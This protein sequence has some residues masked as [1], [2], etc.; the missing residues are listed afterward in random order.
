MYIIFTEEK[1]R[2]YV[3]PETLSG[4][5]YMFKSRKAAISAMDRVGRKYRVKLTLRREK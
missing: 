4:R 5:K 1:R 3:N 2:R